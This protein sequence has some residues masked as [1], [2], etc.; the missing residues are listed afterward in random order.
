MSFESVASE[1]K[2]VPVQIRREPFAIKRNEIVIVM[3]TLFFVY[4]SV[5]GRDSFLKYSKLSRDVGGKKL[6]REI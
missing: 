2:S 6:Y 3:G 4:L 1:H 5:Q